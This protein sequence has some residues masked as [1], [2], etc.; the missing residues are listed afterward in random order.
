V[1]GLR[2]EATAQGLEPA[3]SFELTTPRT[4]IH[5]ALSP[6]FAYGFYVIA[7]DRDAKRRSPPSVPV[8]VDP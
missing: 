3:G 7:W 2:F 4:R 5:V 1:H 8:H 6:G